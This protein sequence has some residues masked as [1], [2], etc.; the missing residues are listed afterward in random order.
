MKFVNIL[1]ND[2]ERC[3][4]IPIWKKMLLLFFSF[5]LIIPN[6]TLYGRYSF[7]QEGLPVLILSV[8][9][10]YILVVLLHSG[11]ISVHYKNSL[12]WITACVLVC[13]F[14]SVGSRTLPTM[15]HFAFL[16]LYTFFPLFIILCNQNHLLNIIIDY[17]S[18]I[19]A[20]LSLASTFLWILGP[21]MGILKPNCSFV[22]TWTNEVGSYKEAPGFFGL[23]YELQWS[24]F[25]SFLGYRNTSIFGEGPAF[26]FYLVVALLIEFFFF[27]KMKK[28]RTVSL[29]AG[30]F[31]SFSTTGW[32]LAL[33]I[34]L[35][36]FYCKPNASKKIKALIS[37]VCACFFCIAFFIAVL[38]FANK[39]DTSSGGIHMDD[40]RAA[41]SAWISSPIWGYGIG[42][43]DAII[44]FMSSF[45][46][47]I[48]GFSNSFLFVL[49]T[50]GLLYF[51]L[52]V[53]PFIGYYRQGGKIRLFGLFY[54]LLVFFSNV[55]YFAFAA[56]FLGYGVSLLLN[57][58]R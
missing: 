2:R 53:I 48:T 43:N 3:A 21:F 23:L 52:W 50:G 13:F 51:S 11:V 25:G 30:L 38:L 31:T 24:E 16:L 20:L 49:A 1:N 14:V 37:F 39:V 9:L 5:L 45:R 18:L 40:F 32:I 41:F 15:G 8:I 22:N 4:L 55:T 29:L 57:I 10:C 26:A 46:L 19:V 6:A 36:A 7:M 56:F 28:W 42:N 44:P 58:S 35:V 17:I 34:L 54:F 33:G 12:F 47:N 27:N